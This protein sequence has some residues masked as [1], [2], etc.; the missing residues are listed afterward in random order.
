MSPVENFSSLTSSAFVNNEII[1]EKFSCK[2]ENINPPLLISNLP[3]SAKYFAII[4]DDPDAPK[5]TY[6]HWVVWDIPS[7][8]KNIPE[9]STLGVAGKNSGGKI[10]YVG[11]CPPAGEHRYHFQVWAYAKPLELKEGSTKKQLLKA[12]HGRAL[13]TA[14]LFGRFGVK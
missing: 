1:P 4:L 10:G 8:N 11:P 7:T 3:P 13:V 14:E 2:G 9:N 5:G 12:L 6:D